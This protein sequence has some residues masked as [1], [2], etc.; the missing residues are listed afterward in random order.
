MTTNFQNEKNL[1]RD[2]YKALDS[3]N[4]NDITKVLQNYISEDYIWRGF[5]PF[6]EISD[7]KKVSEIFWQ[8]F[9]HA[10]KNIQRRMDIFIAGKNQIDGFESV[11]VISMGNLMGSI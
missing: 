9:R 6:N 3:A 4:G 11:W 5:H 8:P 1:I 7:A 2:Y 10:F